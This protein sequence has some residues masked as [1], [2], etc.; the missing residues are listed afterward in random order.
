MFVLKFRDNT[1]ITQYVPSERKH[2]E[3]DVS[4]RYVRYKTDRNGDHSTSRLNK[5]AV[6][7]K[8]NKAETSYFAY[9]CDIVEV[10]VQEREDA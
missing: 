5:A 2:M 8:R 7:Q 1:K 10:E 3:V 9:Q 4:G 6:F